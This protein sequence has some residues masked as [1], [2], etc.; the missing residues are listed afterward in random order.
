MNLQQPQRIGGEDGIQPGI[1]ADRLVPD[2]QRWAAMRLDFPRR[3]GAQSRML[4]PEG[5]RF[6][7]RQR[8]GAH[9]GRDLKRAVDAIG[10][11]PA[12]VAAGGQVVALIGL[13]AKPVAALR[14]RDVAGLQPAA[15]V[16]V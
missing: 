1:A 5:A 16:G 4:A 14:A 7:Q 15:V 13:K 8:Q 9:R 11:Q 3:H 2:D 12:A 6:W 10:V